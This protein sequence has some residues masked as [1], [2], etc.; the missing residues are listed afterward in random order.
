MTNDRGG[1]GGGRRAISV[2]YAS[3]T[4]IPWFMVIEVLWEDLQTAEYM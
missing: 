1:G 2:I 4:G 3:D